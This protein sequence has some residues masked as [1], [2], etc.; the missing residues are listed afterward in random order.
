LESFQARITYPEISA[1]PSFPAGTLCVNILGFREMDIPITS[2]IFDNTSGI[3]TF[4]GFDA[5]GV[6]WPANL[7]HVLIRLTGSADRACPVDLELASLGDGD[8]NPIALPPVLTRLVQRGDAS[9]DGVT[10]IADA[11]FIAEY[12][13]GSL[14]A[15]TSIEDTA[16]LHS[17]NAASVR[18]D[19]AFDQK[20]IADALFI[21]QHRAGLRDEFYRLGP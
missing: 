7:G 21:A 9:A 11:L 14:P 4:D 13:A 17:V 19:G 18:Q 15:C 8:G 12:L 6:P 3:S 20:T 16:C 5:G 1:N 2:R 10:D